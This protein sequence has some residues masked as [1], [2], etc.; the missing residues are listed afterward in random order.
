MLD[1][2]LLGMGA[3][4]GAILAA[5]VAWPL[6][7]AGGYARGVKAVA[8]ELAATKRVANRLLAERDQAR[9][10]VDKVNFAIAAQVKE[11]A[12]LMSADQTARQEAAA[13]ME[14]AANL[15]AKEAKLAG[16]RALAAREVIKNVADQCARAGVPDDVV[17]VLRDITGPAS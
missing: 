7:D 11:L 4:G 10:E 13:R 5:L 17:R 8:E 14:A 15:A 2:K 6:A 3:A 1:F 9:A 16:Q 12:A